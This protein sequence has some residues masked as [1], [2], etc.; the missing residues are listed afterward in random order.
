[1]VQQRS[2]RGKGTYA[3]YKTEG[4]VTKNKIKKLERHCKEFPNDEVGKANLAKVI[5]NGYT[6]RAKPLVPGS[7]PT[8]AKIVGKPFVHISTPAEQLS[9]LLGIPVPYATRNTAKPKVTTKR[10]R[11][12]RKT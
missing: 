4:R 5:K 2:K 12:V 9:K 10:K 1:M 3:V 7:N 6:P 11:N 8:T